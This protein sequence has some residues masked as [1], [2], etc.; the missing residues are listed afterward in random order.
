MARSKALYE[1]AKA[2][3]DANDL[4]KADASMK[5]SMRL[6]G[7]ASRLVVSPEKQAA[8]E[9]EK[10]EQMR[11]SI[12]SFTDAID[13]VVNEADADKKKAE[14]VDAAA[15][16]KLIDESEALASAGKY[17]EANVKLADAYGQASTALTKL[18]DK[19]TILITLEFDT[20]EDEYKY[21]LQRNESYDSLVKILV[22]EK[23]PSERQME[24]IN[25]FVQENRDMLP[26]AKN[27]A[28]AGH[29]EEAI[30]VVD[31]ATKSLSKALRSLGLMVFD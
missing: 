17:K 12:R 31:K 18:R 24:K 16:H 19:E 3:L 21:V 2:A 6:V 13:R 8:K 20:P 9:K 14:G 29:F 1:E 25:S 26:K 5:E 23:N 27:P 7:V 10:Y 11:K 4:E 22:G 28:A 30:K 15:I